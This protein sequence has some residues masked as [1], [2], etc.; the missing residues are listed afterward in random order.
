MSDL[1]ADKLHR[2]GRMTGQHHPKIDWKPMKHVKNSVPGRH[3]AGATS[4]TEHCQLRIFPSTSSKLMVFAPK[5]LK[6]HVT[7]RQSELQA[8]L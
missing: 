7:D 8:R 5:S 6:S 1:A 3:S 4:D 2:L